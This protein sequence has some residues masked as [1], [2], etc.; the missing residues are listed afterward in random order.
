MCFKFNQNLTIN[1]EFDLWGVEGG[2]PPFIRNGGPNPHR[3]FRHSTS[4]RKCL[5]I[6]GI[7]LTFWE[8]KFTPKGG[9]GPDFRN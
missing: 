6:G 3:K 2:G 1:K 9:R 7:D 5:K 4:F 8:V